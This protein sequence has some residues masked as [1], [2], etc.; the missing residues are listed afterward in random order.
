MLGHSARTVKEALSLA[1][2]ELD[3]LTA[4]LDTRLLAGDD[5]LLD[6]ID[7][8]GA[9]AGAEA[10]QPPHRRPLRRRRR[11]AATSPGPIA[12]MLAPNLKDGGGGL[13][14]VQAPG[15]VGWALGPDPGGPGA[16]PG[17]GGVV[18]RRGDAGGARLPARRGPHP[19]A[20]RARP[21]ARRPGRAPS[22]DRRTVRPAHAAGP[23]RGRRASSAPTTPTRSSASS[24]E[25]AR[26]VVWITVRPLVAAARARGTVPAAARAACATLG[27]GVVVRDDR[28]ALELGVDGRHV[29]RARARGARGAS[30]ACRSIATRSPGS[31]TSA[32]SSGR[33][34]ARD[35]FIDVLAAG[36][37][38]IPVF[39]ALDHVGRARAAAPGVGARAGAAATQRVPPLHRR[40]SLA[41]GGRR[42]R[43][44][45]I[46][47]RPT[48]LDG[49]VARART[50]S[51]CCCSARCCTTSARATRATTRRSAPRPRVSVA[52]RIGL[53]D[54]RHRRSSVWLVRNH[55]LLADTATRRD[56][57]DGARSRASPARWATPSGS[58][59][60]TCSRSATRARPGPRRGARARP[61]SCG[62][63][64]SKTDTLFEEGVVVSET[65]AER[66]S[67]A[68]RAD[69]AR[70]RRVPRR[71]AARV[72]HRLPRRRPRPPS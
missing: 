43:A 50:R 23:G 72:H 7:G 49:E 54:A 1:D 32:S 31:A 25:S 28:I 69:R 70:G 47:D 30:W 68:R 39:E 40:P 66:Q 42:V 3:A 65:A 5:E 67:R 10:P 64:S 33:L 4:L 19:P 16:T 13:R 11:A 62:S 12:E 41:R 21:V 44:C 26:A 36:R 57:S 46:R 56:L 35:A 58:T 55:L 34:T 60:S 18:H 15:W 17:S 48:G 14:D 71:H 59:C 2:S 53:D 6:D 8:Q 52:R 29:A 61:R 24:G 51:T 45:S 22:R 20:R 9:A 63:C 27:D 38:A 37:G